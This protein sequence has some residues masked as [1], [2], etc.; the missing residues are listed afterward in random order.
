[1]G[2]CDARDGDGGAAAVGGCQQRVARRVA[3]VRDPR[4]AGNGDDGA[5]Q[6]LREDA[7]IANVKFEVRV[8]LAD[9]AWVGGLAGG[10][11]AGD[12]LASAL[13]SRFASAQSEAAGGTQPCAPR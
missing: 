10:T 8:D 9:D 3:V 11:D 5:Q 13:L 4:R 12:A 1:M 6:F 7:Y 2:T